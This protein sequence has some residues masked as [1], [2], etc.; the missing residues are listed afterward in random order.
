MLYA[1]NCVRYSSK[2]VY[3]GHWEDTETY[4]PAG[5]RYY[6]MGKLINEVKEEKTYTYKSWSTSGYY[7]G[8]FKPTHWMPFPH[9]PQTA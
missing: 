7:G 9:P 8:D 5:S 4:T 1:P 2:G 3:V 6:S